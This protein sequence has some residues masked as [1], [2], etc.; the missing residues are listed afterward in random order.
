[1]SV[2]FSF[3][4]VLFRIYLIQDQ[5]VF[6]FLSESYL[7]DFG[8]IAN[9]LALT[10]GIAP[11]TF[12]RNVDDSLTHFGSRN[13]ATEFLNVLNSQDPQ[14]QH[15]IEYKNDNKERNFS[16]VAVRNNLN[17]SYDF[18]VYRK[19]AITNFHIK[20]HSNIC[21]S[22]TIGVFKELLARA[23]HIVQKR[24]FS[25][26]TAHCSEKY[27]AQKKKI[28]DKRFCRKWTQYYSLEKVTKN[29]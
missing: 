4:T 10:F 25:M 28:F 2:L 29:I 5:L 20:S 27:L 1:M 19:T 11:K 24:V 21:P 7:Q 12:R 22:I 18:A 15:T 14:I 3:G 9:Y 8:K 23:L 17:H 26:R 13:N 6:Q 16:D